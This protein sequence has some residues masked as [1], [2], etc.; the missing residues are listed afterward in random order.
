M[1]EVKVAVPRSIR[2][3][4]STKVEGC[5]WIANNDDPISVREVKYV[6]YIESGQMQFTAIVSG[7]N[8]QLG[9][10]MWGCNSENPREEIPEFVI[11][12][13]RQLAEQIGCQLVLGKK[14]GR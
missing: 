11:D 12:G 5:P 3:S 1:S 13:A 6:C 8:A 2:F 9:A 4:V 10:R 14:R 7:F